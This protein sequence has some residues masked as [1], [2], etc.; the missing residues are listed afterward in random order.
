MKLCGY[1][2]LQRTCWQEEKSLARDCLRTLTEEGD[3]SSFRFILVEL[4]LDFF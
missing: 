2:S 4:F 1:L 3:D